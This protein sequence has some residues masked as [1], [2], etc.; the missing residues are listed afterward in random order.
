MDSSKHKWVGLFLALAAVCDVP[1]V[2]AALTWPGCKDITDADFRVTN[3]VTRAADKVEE[4]MKMAFDL[5][6]APGEDAKGKVDVYFTERNGLL[7][8][9]DSKQNKVLTL[10]TFDLVTDGKTSD[11]LL[12]IALDPAF[13]KNH[14]LFLYYS[15]NGPG[16]ISWR[17]SRFTLDNANQTLDMASEK[18]L[19]KIPEKLVTTHPGGALQFDAYGDLWITVGNNFLNG[20]TEFPVWSSSNTNDLRGKILRIHP[21]P[22]GSYSIPDGN[23]FP[24]GK[25]PPGKTRPE[26]YIMGTRNPYTLALDPVRRWAAF[27][28]IGPD[29]LTADGDPLNANPAQDNTEEQDLAVGPGNFGFP[30]FAG[31]N[32]VM[33]KG[34]NPLQPII[35]A[36]MDWAGVPHNGLDTLPPAIPAIHPYPRGCAITGPIYR[37][38]GDLNSSIKLPPHFDRKWFFTDFNANAKNPITLATLSADGKS[39]TASEQVLKGVTLYKPLDFQQGPDGAL[40]VNNYAGY[41]TV[42]AETG[43]IRIDYIGDC[44]PALPKLESP[45]TLAMTQQASPAG[46][47]LEIIQARGL[48]VGVTAKGSFTLD[49]RDMRG[50][51]LATHN[52]QGQMRVTLE[53]LHEPGIYFVTATSQEGRTTRKF[54]VTHTLED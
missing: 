51:I 31:A 13:K 45:S 32:R 23:L 50:K 22:D 38:D 15:F 34:I 2:H 3:L 18:I 37:Y 17:I 52:G 21:K 39:I 44:R 42:T 40:Y 5:L 47:G 12:G 35:P 41:R 6:A 54:F 33:K 24:E 16:E 29:N 43:I 10:A 53:K 9:Y 8:K 27:G 25:Y 19:L 46:P 4:P 26:I 36:G 49:L 1:S 20:A 14:Q 28:D 30:F 11:G 48:S 7:R